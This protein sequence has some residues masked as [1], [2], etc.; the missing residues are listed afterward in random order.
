V[1]VL[2]VEDHRLFGDAIQ[3]LLEDHGMEVVQATT[4][5]AALK[6]IALSSVDVVLV[7]LGLPDMTGLELGA[8][9]LETNP[10]LKLI[11]VTA[12]EDP[13]AVREAIQLGFQGYLTKDMPIPQFVELMKAIM[14]GQVIIP[15]RLA[16]VAAG[17]RANG[18]SDPRELAELLTPREW[19]VLALLVEG[20]TSQ[21][22][23]RVLSISGNTVRTHIQSV[24][25]KLQ[26]HSRLEAAAFAVRHGLI[27]TPRRRYA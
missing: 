17:G 4:G 2:I 22:L 23:M 15:N 10:D 6:E 12:L 18:E 11:A 3:R 7:D 27:N 25:T 13:R 21:D 8:T 20:L 19:D 14:G 26:V 1:R 9:I 24:L 5:R 16:R